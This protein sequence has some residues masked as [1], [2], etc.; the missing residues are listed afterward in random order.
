MLTRQRHFSKCALF[1]A[2][3][4]RQ[5]YADAALPKIKMSTKLGKLMNAYADRNGAQHDPKVPF[6]AN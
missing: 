4:Y 5:L 1:Y 6:G 2:I 3:G